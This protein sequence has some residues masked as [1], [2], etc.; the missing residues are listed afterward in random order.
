MP[1]KQ[2]ILL[3]NLGS[4]EAPT[5]KAVRKYLSQFLHDKRVIELTRWL[6]CPV[7]HGMILRT[8]P[9]RS[10]AAYAKIWRQDTGGRPVGPGPLIEH[11]NAIAAKLQDRAGADTLVAV[12]MR[13][14]IPSLKE[15]FSA[16]EQAGCHRITVL[17]LYPQFT[18]A[19]TAS[20]Q[21]E[22]VRVFRKY[23]RPDIRMIEDYHDHP[24]Y[25]LALAESV[26]VR[27]K[28]LS[29]TPDRLL[30]SFHGIPKSSVEKGDPY[31]RQCERTFELL[32]EA[33]AGTD[34]R[35]VLSYQSQFGPKK[36]LSPSTQV[37][38]KRLPA[39][40]SSN[41]AVITPGFA[42]DCLETL[43]EIAIEGEE[44]FKNAGGG[45]FAFIPCLNDSD[46]HILALSQILADFNQVQ[47]G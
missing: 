5:P 39:Q 4:P 14:G 36:W 21:D 22:I 40:D 11:T 23:T 45:R 1:N 6:W 3:I 10:A 33:L 28:S 38:L 15:G 20:V 41:V 29:W 44:I 30:V 47:R 35:P 26:R 7:L 13:Y 46:A 27:V 42:A 12:G 37:L 25:I 31:E 34:I 43:E 24:A 32:C 16:L 17:P 18:G 9:R 8:R 2:G 19:T